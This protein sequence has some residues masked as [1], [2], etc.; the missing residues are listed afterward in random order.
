MLHSTLFG[1]Y[2]F[3]TVTIQLTL[4]AVPL[5]F[6]LHNILAVFLNFLIRPCVCV[7]ISIAALRNLKRIIGI[8]LPRN[9]LTYFFI[10]YLTLV[11]FLAETL[12][13][14]CIIEISCSSLQQNPVG[15]WPQRGWQLHV[16]VPACCRYL[17]G[18]TCCMLSCL[19]LSICT[20][21]NQNIVVCNLILLASKRICIYHSAII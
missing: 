2:L 11:S 3:F 6:C 15:S 21:K 10:I 18:F 8:H 16:T 12:I 1:A 5:T 13:V 14:F 4:Q 9:S 7:F 20:F 17:L 19:T